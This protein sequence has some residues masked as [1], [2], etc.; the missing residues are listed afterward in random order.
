MIVIHITEASDTHDYN[1]VPNVGGVYF[2][3]QTW[4]L[5]WRKEFYLITLPCYMVSHLTLSAHVRT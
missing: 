1:S 4:N 3:R 5:F 2:Y